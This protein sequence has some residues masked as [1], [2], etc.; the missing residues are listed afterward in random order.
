MNYI[1]RLD[2]DADFIALD[3]ETT[4]HSTRL[5][6]VTEIGAIR[7]RAGREI[8]RFVTLVKPE[9]SML[10][11]VE[12]LTGITDDMLVG[13]PAPEKVAARLVKFLRRSP[14]VVHNASFDVPI[15][16][17]FLSQATSRPWS[18]SAVLCTLRLSRRLLPHLQSRRLAALAEYFDFEPR[19]SNVQFHRAAADAEAAAHVFFRLAE[20]VE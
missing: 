17:R 3:L 2:P 1:D 7:Y 14:L 15:L 13:A 5:S 8:E 11:W 19:F 16:E 12:Q 10:P 20:S 6:V 4:G 9:T 18:A